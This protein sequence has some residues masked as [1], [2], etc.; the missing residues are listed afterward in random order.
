MHRKRSARWVYKMTTAMALA[1][2]AAGCTHDPLGNRSMPDLN[3]ADERAEMLLRYCGKLVSAGDLVVAASICQRAYETN[4]SDSEPLYRLADIYK[5]LGATEQAGSVYRQALMMNPDDFEALYGLAK[6]SMDLGKYEEAEGQLERALQVDDQDPRVYNALGIVKDQK[7][8]HSVAQALYRTGLL[9]D[10]GNV[11]LRNNL[12]LSLALSGE[13]GESIEMLRGVAGA[14]GT[15]L[16]SSQNLALA[17]TYQ[18]PVQQRDGDGPIEIRS[19]DDFELASA[20]MFEDGAE[21]ATARAKP[22]QKQPGRPAEP[23]GDGAETNLAAAA[24]GKPVQLGSATGTVGSAAEGGPGS[25]VSA[26]L[27]AGLGSRANDPSEIGRTTSRKAPKSRSA[28]GKTAKQTAAKP[29][30]MADKEYRVQLGAFQSE[31]SADKAWNR[32]MESSKDLL[33]DLDRKVVKAE[34]G[35]D[36]GV[37]YRLRAGPLDSRAASDDL[38]A[39]LKERSLGCFVVAPAKGKA[40]AKAPVPTMKI[41]SKPLPAPIN[42]APT[43][44]PAAQSQPSGSPAPTPLQTPAT[45]DR[46]ALADPTQIQG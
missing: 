9:I 41:E 30:M 13:Q 18:A 16:V 2:F 6:T 19:T 39:K 43:S 24:P 12:G 7:G 45:Q 14:P 29:A 36:L 11:P 10:P 35:T 1:L 28:K 34:S 4:P 23:L 42:P 38:C 33:G 21:A 44:T 20:P 15:G 3:D 40:A 46:K 32:L 17:S 37:V 22:L 27:P 26:S 25:D 5:Q 8:E 31:A